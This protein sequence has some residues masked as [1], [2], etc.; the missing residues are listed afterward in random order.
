MSKGIPVDQLPKEL[1]SKI[2]KDNG[3]PTRK[4]ALNKDAIRGYAIAALN[5]IRD[6]TKNDR[7]R[8]LNH[9]QQ[10]NKI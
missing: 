6:L 4:Q 10:M 5:Q 1:Q 9:A 2:K 7:V 8:V 3:I